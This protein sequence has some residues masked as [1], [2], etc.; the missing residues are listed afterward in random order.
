MTALLVTHFTFSAISLSVHIETA[1]SILQS[2]LRGWLSLRW[3]TNYSPLW[4]PHV[5]YCIHETL[6]LDITC[7]F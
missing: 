1:A 6:P 4:N 3:S 5:H 2:T 7:Q